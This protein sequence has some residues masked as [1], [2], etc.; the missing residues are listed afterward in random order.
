[1]HA[2]KKLLAKHINKATAYKLNAQY[3]I[4]HSMNYNQLN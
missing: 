4:V 2:S 1:M 3:I